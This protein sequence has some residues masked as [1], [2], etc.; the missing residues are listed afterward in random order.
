MTGNDRRKINSSIDKIFEFI[1]NLQLAE[2]VDTDMEII[3][4]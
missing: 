1:E 3:N 2:I 4:I